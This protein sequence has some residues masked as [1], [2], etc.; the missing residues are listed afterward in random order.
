M[1]YRYPAPKLIRRID[2]VIA[3]L[4]HVLAAS[5]TEST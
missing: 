1:R 4:A 5:V 2:I 3:A